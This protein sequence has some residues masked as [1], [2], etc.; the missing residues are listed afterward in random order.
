MNFRQS[1]RA[2]YLN[3]QLMKGECDDGRFFFR[4]SN[5]LSLIGGNKNCFQKCCSSVFDNNAIAHW[6]CKAYRTMVELRG[7]EKWRRKIPFALSKWNL[8]IWRQ[9]MYIICC[10]QQSANF[11]ALAHTPHHHHHNQDSCVEHLLNAQRKFC[12]ILS[13]SSSS[14][15]SSSTRYARRRWSMPQRIKTHS[16][17]EQVGE[18]A[19]DKCRNINFLFVFDVRPVSATHTVSHSRH[20]ASSFHHLWLLTIDSAFSCSLLFLMPLL[21]SYWFGGRA[22]VKKSIE[23][24]T[25]KPLLCFL[26]SAYTHTKAKIVR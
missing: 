14:S 12:I 26:S 3:I 23:I 2:A 8:I 13:P 22:V 7:T 5:C 16:C 20:S 19:Q 17:W 15:S 21:S 4:S 10:L 9:A 25:S 18:K 1:P 6:L 24:W 11:A